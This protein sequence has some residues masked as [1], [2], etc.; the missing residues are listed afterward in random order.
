MG[1][2]FIRLEMKKATT[3]GGKERE[4]A[5]QFV[6]SYKWQEGLIRQRRR[7]REREKAKGQFF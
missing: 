5:K 6:V 1:I 3:E 2:L 7:L 4:K